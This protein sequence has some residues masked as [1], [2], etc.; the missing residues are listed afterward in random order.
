ME[1]NMNIVIT[2]DKEKYRSIIRHMLESFPV[3]IIGEAAN[4]KELLSML[5]KKQPDIVLLDLEMPV[6][7]GNKAFQYISRQ[8]PEQKVIILSAYNE[9][10]L[11]DDYIARGAKGFIPKDEMAPELLMEALTKV[12]KNGIFVYEPPVQHLKFTYRQKQIM[13]LIFEGMTNDQIATE[14][15]MT[16]RSVEK[17][18]HKLYQKSGAQRIID[19]YKYAFTRG[20]QFLGR[21]KKR[22]RETA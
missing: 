11:I 9:S 2:D 6:M 18:R 1:S 20:L 8:W 14:I 17:Q 13:P 16:K 22:K 4:G 3:N 21:Q 15:C 5:R 12:S 19:F 7:D 10:V